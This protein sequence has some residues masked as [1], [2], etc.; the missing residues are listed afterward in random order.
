MN[1]VAVKESRKRYGLVIYSHLKDS[2]FTAV[3]R[4]AKFV[5]MWEGSVPF[6]NR[7][8]TKEYLFCQKWYIK[9]WG[10]SPRG[11]ISPYSSFSSTPLGPEPT[12]VQFQLSQWTQNILKK[13]TRHD[14]KTSGAVKSQKKQNKTKCDEMI[15]IAHLN[16]GSF[17]ILSTIWSFKAS[18]TA[19]LISNPS[20]AKLM[21]GWTR[22]FQ[23]NQPYSFQARYRPLTSPGT[24]MARP[25]RRKRLK[26]FSSLRSKRFRLVWEQRKTEV[27]ER[28]SWHWPREKWNEWLLFFVLCS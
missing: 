16:P 14:S 12:T 5:G 28:D 2:V 27:E 20:L 24:A 22:S 19:V 4:K 21:A 9:G 11:G 7:R 23:G 10:V 1:F 25:P 6:D 8:Y 15:A 17:F 13:D 3:E 18:A 26:V